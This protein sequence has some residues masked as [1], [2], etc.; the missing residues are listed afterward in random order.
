MDLDATFSHLEFQDV[1]VPSIKVN[2]A[3]GVPKNLKFWMIL[4]FHAHISRLTNN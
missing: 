4:I 2:L 1:G 3:F